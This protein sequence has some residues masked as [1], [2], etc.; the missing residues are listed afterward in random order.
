MMDSQASSAMRYYESIYDRYLSKI[1][2]EGDPTKLTYSENPKKQGFRYIWTDE[3]I[4][5]MR[6]LRKQ[7]ASYRAIAREFNV[8][9]SIIQRACHRHNIRD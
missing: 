3:D 2:A 5:K 9:M 4:E 6:R 7:G 8:A 1:P